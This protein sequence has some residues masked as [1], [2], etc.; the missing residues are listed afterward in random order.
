[1][2]ALVRAI[3]TV[4]HETGRPVI[5]IGGLAVICRLTT[6][7]RATDDLDTVTRHR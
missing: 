4:A 1:M 6:P 5:V 3:P 7:Y 2:S